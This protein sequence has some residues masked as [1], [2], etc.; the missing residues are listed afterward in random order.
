MPRWSSV[1]IRR[2]QIEWLYCQDP[3]TKKLYPV[4]STWRSETFCG[5]YTCKLRKK[6]LT[7]TEYV[8]ITINITSQQLKD[9][10]TIS[11]ND[12]MSVSPS[13]NS[14]IIKKIDPEKTPVFHRNLD[15][16]MNELKEELKNNKSEV[17]DRYLTEAEIQKITD[18]LHTIKKSDLEAIV[19]I[20]NVAQEIHKELDIVV[21]E[22]M[23]KDTVNSKTDEIKKQIPSQTRKDSISYWYEPLHHNN[24]KHKPVE[25]KTEGTNIVQTA[26]PYLYP[27]SYVKRPLQESEFQKLP[28][29]YPTS[30]FHRTLS[31]LHNPY[32]SK[33]NSRQESLPCNKDNIGENSLV[34][35]WYNPF[36]NN[37]LELYKKSSA[38]QPMM[39]PYPFSYVHHNFTNPASYYY[40]NYPWAQLNSY[41]RNKQYLQPYY[42]PYAA[43]EPRTAIIANPDELQGKYDEQV[44][45]RTDDTKTKNK[46]LPEW[47]TEPLSEKILD[48]VKANMLEK[49]KILK[50][51]SLRKTLKL[52]KVGK[53]IKLDDLTR[54]KRDVYDVSDN[55]VRDK[56]SG[57]ETYETYIEKT[58]CESS[59]EPGYF[60]VGNE[61]EPYPACCPRRINS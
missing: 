8:P 5:N 12:D 57:G 53:V 37:N 59:L 22:R 2:L 55:E 36:V 28:Y 43:Q 16:K 29:Y 33:Q 26:Y 4:N 30:S 58:M 49:S 45:V 52:E 21:T 38:I 60:S 14:I 7:E 32:K 47:Q 9:E 44:E 61:T 20:Y 10:Y 19:E 11:N 31:Y 15:N 54:S 3:D 39:L 24:G 40:S 27:D 25:L 51:L 6:N 50:P 18:I 17:T 46:E 23:D 42:G 56:T 35:V 1:Y 34:P 41:N 48:E 13:D